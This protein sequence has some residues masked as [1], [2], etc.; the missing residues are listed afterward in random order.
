MHTGRKQEVEEGGMTLL[1]VG[2]RAE[3][4]ALQGWMQ[5][6]VYQLSNTTIIDTSDDSG[7]IDY[8]NADYHTES[9]FVTRHTMRDLSWPEDATI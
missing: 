1:A 9:I 7:R 3:S 6:P 5:Q 4:S 8:R 2:S